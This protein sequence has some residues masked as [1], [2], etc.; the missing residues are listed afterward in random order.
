MTQ[1]TFEFYNEEANINFMRTWLDHRTI[2]EAAEA[3]GASRQSY[4][5]FAR[6]YIDIPIGE[7][8]LPYIEKFFETWDRHNCHWTEVPA[9][10]V[11][12]LEEADRLERE[13]QEADALWLNS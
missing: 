5:A 11:L 10:Q 1:L 3:Q 9:M 8:G 7:T 4:F 13:V 2:T 12:D 6:K